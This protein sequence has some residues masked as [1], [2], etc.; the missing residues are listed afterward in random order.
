MFIGNAFYSLCQWGIIALLAK[1]GSTKMVGQFTLGLAIT[2][3]IIMFTNLQ[4]R[5]VQA[6]DANDEYTFYEYFTLRLILTL[7]GL[8]L[9]TGITLIS[10]YHSETILVIL[11]VG[12]CKAVESISDIFYGLF[13]KHERMDRIGKSKIMRGF[14]SLPMLGHFSKEKR[15]RK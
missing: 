14:I 3:P 12:F 4:L 8:L 5:T 10:N 11:L 1:L 9:I 15:T 7:L 13:Q 2:A 6:T